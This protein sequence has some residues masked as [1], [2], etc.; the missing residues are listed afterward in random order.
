[1]SNPGV[2]SEKTFI[3]STSPIFAGHQHDGIMFTQSLVVNLGMTE[4]TSTQPAMIMCNTWPLTAKGQRAQ[5]NSC[6]DKTKEIDGGR[7]DTSINTS[8]IESVASG[9]DCPV[10]EFMQTIHTLTTAT[11]NSSPWREQA[12]LSPSSV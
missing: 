11:A 6:E 10:A 1:M 5:S 4:S 12:T 2:D 7:Q 9:A 3:R 8:V